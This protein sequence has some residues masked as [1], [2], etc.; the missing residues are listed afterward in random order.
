MLPGSWRLVRGR[1]RCWSSGGKRSRA[2]KRRASAA[3]CGG[4]TISFLASCAA[5][6]EKIVG[7]VRRRPFLYIT[8][9]LRSS[10][11]S[12]Y[13]FV[14]HRILGQHAMVH[15]PLRL[16]FAAHFCRSNAAWTCH[17]SSCACGVPRHETLLALSARVCVTSL[18]GYAN[19]GIGGMTLQRSRA[20]FQQF[21]RFSFFWV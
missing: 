14:F 9:M 10:C 3:T 8:A 18:R 11:S 13:N 19:V 15:F 5:D 20:T 6:V 21:D 12:R 17:V 16:I 2:N 4:A 7:R 1:K